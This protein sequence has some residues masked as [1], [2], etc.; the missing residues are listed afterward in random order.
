MV[1][2][3]WVALGGA[4]GAVTRHGLNLAV[5][6]R[7]FPWA[8]LLIN[9]TG[10]FALGALLFLA[11]DR[12]WSPEVTAA[13]GVGFLGAYTTF[14]TFTFEA[15]GL[16]RTDRMAVAALYVAL[17]VTAGI[18]AAALGHTAARLASS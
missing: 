2:F 7:S 13:L 17:S 15:F 5:G 6:S 12:Q 4:A 16:G 18:L 10:S 14:S 11:A 8:T 9:L 3:L 1:R